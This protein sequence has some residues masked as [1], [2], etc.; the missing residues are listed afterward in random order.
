MQAAATGT[1]SSAERSYPTS[2]V[3]AEAGRTPC[4]KGG[5]QEELPHVQGRGSR[6]ECQATTA[7]ER[8]KGATL[9]PRSGAVA[10][11]SSPAS[12]ARD[13][14]QEYYSAIKRNAFESVLMRLMNLEPIVQSEVRKRKVNIVF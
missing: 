1:R 9:H 13:G 4:P 2:E 3:R 6:L 5:G 11:R 14:S 8:L 12:E 7:Q 10:R